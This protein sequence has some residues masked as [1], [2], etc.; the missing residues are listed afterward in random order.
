MRLKVSLAIF[1]RAEESVTFDQPGRVVDLAKR[2]QRLTQFFN[3]LE[4]AHP[5]QVFLEGADEPLGTAIAFRGPDEGGRNLDAEESDLFL[6]L[7]GHVLRSVIVAHR[8]TVS[9]RL[10]ESA[11]MLPHA[12]PDR[13]QGLE[14]GGLKPIRQ[15][16]D[17]KG[18]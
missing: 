8:Q 13:L 17:R 1:S 4:S 18:T 2:Q 12:L 5:R 3:I 15:G 6:E 7:V 10:G 9:D 14:A 11:E 16:V